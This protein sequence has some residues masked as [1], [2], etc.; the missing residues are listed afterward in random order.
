MGHRTQALPAEKQIEAVSKKLMELNPGFDG[1]VTIASGNGMPKIESGMVTEIGF[2]TDH[3]ADISPVRLFGGLKA[4]SC[5][6][7]GRTTSKLSDI[8]PLEGMQLLSVNLGGIKVSDLSPL[9]GMHLRYLHCGYTQVSDLSSL[10]GMK[11]DNLLCHNTPIS[12][13][14]PLQGMSLNDLRFTPSNITK[15]LNIIRQMKSLET[16]GTSLTE[17][18]AAADFWK[19]YDAGEFGKSEAKAE[20]GKRKAGRLAYLDPAFQQWVKATQAL[21]AEQQIEAVSKKLMELNPGFDGKI[22]GW[23]G[24]GGPKIEGNVVTEL[25]LVAGD[26]ADLSPV[27]ALPELRKLRC[28]GF[29]GQRFSIS[30][31]SPLE[32]MALTHLELYGTQVSDLSALKRMQ[33]M[34]LGLGRTSIVDLSPLQGSPIAELRCEFTNVE[35][36]TPLQGCNRLERLSVANTKVSPAQV[37]TLQKAL[38]NCKIKWDD[39]A[40]ATPSVDRDRRAAEWALSL[41]DPGKQNQITAEEVGGKGFAL[42]PGMT[43]PETPFKV[44]TIWL[45]RTTIKEGDLNGL[46]T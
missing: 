45:Y 14:S 15:G 38:P 43:I 33:L 9:R 41:N 23:S 27:R 25:G 21:S 17:N 42:K 6:G 24:G 3:V 10:E 37:A 13:L 11:L 22:R 32:G 30:D 44:H 2:F 40:K 4:L 8:S 26:S 16:I 39:P 28:I 46:K 19:R 20:S 34:D 7:S 36:L 31:L 35:N 29:A 12:D 1:K 5:N 18:L